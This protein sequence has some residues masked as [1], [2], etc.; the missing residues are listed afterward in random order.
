MNR[1]IMNEERRK[2]RKLPPLSDIDYNC[3]DRA[4]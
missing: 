2:R 3:I 1:A 4:A